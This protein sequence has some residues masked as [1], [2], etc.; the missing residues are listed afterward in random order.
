MSSMIIALRQLALK[1]FS[2]L[3]AINVRYLIDKIGVY[4][5]EDDALQ[6]L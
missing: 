2:F 5:S 1:T 4:H 6:N 3:L